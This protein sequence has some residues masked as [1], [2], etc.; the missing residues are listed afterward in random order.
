MWP[1]ANE[2][3]EAIGIH[4][5]GGLSRVQNNTVYDTRGGQ[6]GHPRRCPPQALGF[7]PQM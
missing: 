4:V 3:G 1:P 6:S 5:G 7:S 2:G